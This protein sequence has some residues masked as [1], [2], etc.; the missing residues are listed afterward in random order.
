MHIGCAARVVEKQQL[1]R[2][3]IDLGVGRHA[4]G[5]EGP[6]PARRA[7]LFERDRV[8]LIQLAALVEGAERHAAVYH[9]VGAGAVF[10]IAMRATAGPLGEWRHLGDARPQRAA[11]GLFGQK[12]LGA[13][14]AVAVARTAVVEAE[15]VNHAIAIKGV[16]A[17]QRLV[18]RVFGIAQIDAVEVFGDGTHHHVEVFGV[19]LLVAWCPGPVEVGVIAGAQC[20][21]NTIDDGGFH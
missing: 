14:E 2:G 4:L 3:L 5:R 8:E 7:I 13:H 12:T 17:P 19:P 15:A 18:H 21:G 16:I 1:T 10:E 11:G 6:M 20:C 9:H